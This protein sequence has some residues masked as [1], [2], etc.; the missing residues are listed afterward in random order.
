MRDS[1]LCAPDA[2]DRREDAALAKGDHHTVRCRRIKSTHRRLRFLRNREIAEHVGQRLYQCSDGT[3][4]LAQDTLE[5][6]NTR[7]AC[8]NRTLRWGAFIL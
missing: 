1:P 2:A 5:R 8:G 3:G 6:A 4:I 7:A